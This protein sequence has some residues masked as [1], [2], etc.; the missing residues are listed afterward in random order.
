MGA[1]VPID[2]EKIR[3]GVIPE[4]IA[5]ESACVALPQERIFWAMGDRQ[6]FA[7]VS[8]HNPTSPFLTHV[9]TVIFPERFAVAKAILR[10]EIQRPK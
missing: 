8:V 5:F 2:E 6:R 10:V 1:G 7:A 4:M 9:G 3:C